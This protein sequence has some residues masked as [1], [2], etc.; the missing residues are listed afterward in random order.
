MSDGFTRRNT[1]DVDKKLDAEVFSREGVEIF[2]QRTTVFHEGFS[3]QLDYDGAGN[4]LYYGRAL[5][6][7]AL[8]AANWAIMKLD[9]DLNENVTSIRWAGGTKEFEYVWD[10]RASLSY[11]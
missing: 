1:A 10:N 4:L 7:T 8:S 3:R 5:P 2:R 11:S 9:Y 6:G